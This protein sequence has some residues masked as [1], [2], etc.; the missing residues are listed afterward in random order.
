MY[1]RA[2]EQTGEFCSA[3]VVLMPTAIFRAA[4]IHGIRLIIAGFSD[5]LEAPPKET[6]YMDRTCFRNIMKGGFSRKEL[7]WD[8][9][10]PS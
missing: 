2:L 5:E 8:F 10:F 4:D 1:K 9:F 3:C 6:S 7:K